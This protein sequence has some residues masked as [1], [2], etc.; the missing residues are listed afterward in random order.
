MV[1][2]CGFLN[3]LETAYIQVDQK[4]IAS[5]LDQAYETRVSDLQKSIDLAQKALEL[6]QQAAI[7]KYI[8]ESLCKLSLFYM[9]TGRNEEAINSARKAI[10]I[11]T[12][13]KDEKGI[14]D[15]K[16]NIAGTYYKTDQFHLGLQELE[17]C[18]IIYR[19]HKDY[20]SQARAQKSMGTIYEYFGDTRS[21]TMAY[22][23]SVQAGL[24][25]KNQDLVSN[26][27]N[28]LSGILMKSGKKDE[29]IEMIEKSISIKKETGDIRGLAF[30]IYGRGK[31]HARLEQFEKAEADYNEALRIHIESGE[32]LG[33]TMVQRKMAALY[34]QM[35][36][37]ERAKETANLC[38]Q[39]SGENNIALIKSDTY[40]LLYQI[41]KIE[42]DLENALNYLEAY[43]R[44]KERIIS[45]RHHKMIK[46]YEITNRIN[47]LEIEAE[48]QREKAEII[49][50]KNQELDLFF[51]RVS[52][53]LKGPIAS[54]V[55][56]D[57]VA[58]S[59]IKDGK[60]HHFLDLARTQTTRINLILDELIKL[61]RVT[62]STDAHE[63]IDFDKLISQ[64]LMSFGSLPN[65]EKVRIEKSVASDLDFHAPW[66]LVNTIVQNLLE[67]GIKYARLD[68]EESFV[69]IK[70]I[71]NLD[72][73][74]IVVQDNGVG[75]RK[76][77]GEKI[78]EMF[79]RAEKDIQGSGLGLYI[80]NR[81]VEKLDGTISLESEPNV[82]STFNVKLPK[83][84]SL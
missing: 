44:E 27:Y 37:L 49:E 58:R 54:L 82:G 75:M 52:H 59:E 72:H 66:A 74:E 60:V 10:E 77:T 12:E 20:Y 29:A 70:V 38:L 50:K 53:D 13:L 31:I 28:P 78:F 39:S 33:A 35:G 68:Q 11:F 17:E 25:C 15:A 83:K 79:Y 46:S 62:H 30:A 57:Y 8:A 80:L 55:S 3:Q 9:I 47:T 43:T 64:C 23:S 67:N 73:I 63:A 24:K 34:F 5:L 36:L 26:A 16:Y 21:A 2:L 69:K 19:K 61:T 6:S 45:E 71:D 51:H 32:K 76:D 18:L 4:K 41:S 56:I 22:E 42:N 84:Q 65:F 1:K 14:A 7:P 40:Y 81:A 48:S